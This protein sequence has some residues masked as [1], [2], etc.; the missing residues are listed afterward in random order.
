MGNRQRPPYVG[1][2]DDDESVC[3]AL[4]RLFRVSGMH[5]VTYL[6]GEEFLRDPNRLR[7]DCLILDI[8]LGGMSGLELQERLAEGGSTM[9]VIFLTAHDEPA[10]RER[11]QRMGCAA[12]LGK[13]DA[14]DALFAAVDRAI[15]PKT[16]NSL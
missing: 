6:S 4:A 9:P 13:S 2:V 16:R 15:C 3:C 8:Q 14:A 10:L 5:A 1:V 7:F 12:F 11:A